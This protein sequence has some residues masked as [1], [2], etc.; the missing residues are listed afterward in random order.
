MCYV[1]LVATTESSHGVG[2]KFWEQGKDWELDPLDS[3][4]EELAYNLAKEHL[5]HGAV[6]LLVVCLNVRIAT[7]NC[8]TRKNSSLN[9][10]PELSDVDLGDARRLDL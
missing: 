2:V 7:A 5:F 9:L 3:V 10:A 8:D 1:A 6:L 4:L